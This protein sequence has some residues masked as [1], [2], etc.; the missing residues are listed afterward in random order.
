MVLSLWKQ[1][2]CDFFHCHEDLWVSGQPS[3]AVSSWA[4]DE[5]GERAVVVSVYLLICRYSMVQYYPINVIRHNEHHQSTLGRVHFLWTRRTGMLPFIWLGFQVSSTW[6]SPGFVQESRYLPFGTGPTKPVR[7]HSSAIVAPGKFHVVSN[8]LQVFRKPEYRAECGAQFCDILRHPLLTHSQYIGDQHPRG[9]QEVE[10]CFSLRGV[11][12]CGDY[13]E[14]HSRHSLINCATVRYDNNAS[15]YASCSPC[16]HYCVLK[17]RTTFILIQ[18]RYSSS[19]N[20]V[21][22]RSHYPHES[23]HCSRF[24]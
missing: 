23:Q 11:V 3:V 17:P 1:Q 9:K 8:A 13:P 6:A 7:L 16:K 24:P 4:L 10:L 21:L 15:P 19:V 2:Q 12:L 18:E 20:M 14:R 5:R 22:G